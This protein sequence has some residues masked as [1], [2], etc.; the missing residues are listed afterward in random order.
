MQ[1]TT[2]RRTIPKLKQ[3]GIPISK[4]SRILVELYTVLEQKWS[5]LTFEGI[6]LQVVTDSKVL[7]RVG[8]IT[9]EGQIMW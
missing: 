6:F 2:L 1:G 9:F 4:L 7:K 3:P 8:V 5:V